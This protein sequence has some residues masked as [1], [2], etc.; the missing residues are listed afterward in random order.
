MD[1]TSYLEAALVVEFCRESRFAKERFDEFLRAMGSLEFR[2]DTEAEV[3]TKAV[4]AAFEQV[5][6]VA[7]DDLNAEFA[8][9][10]KKR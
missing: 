10:C 7:I 1:H 3:G 4:M 2:P 8:T 6:G 9:Y 5:Y